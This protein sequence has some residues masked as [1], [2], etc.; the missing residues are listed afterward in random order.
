MFFCKKIL[1]F[2][3]FSLSLPVIT[4]DDKTF[5]RN[6]YNYKI[7]AIA[8][9]CLCSSA[10]FAQEENMDTLFDTGH[11]LAYL[12]AG[13]LISVFAMMF[14]NRLYYY[15]EKKE[16]GELERSFRYQGGNMINITSEEGDVELKL[17]SPNAPGVARYYI[18]EG[19]TASFYLPCYK[20]DVEYT[21]GD[22]WFDD[23][24]GFGEFGETHE[25]E[26]GLR[27]KYS[28]E[29]TWVIFYTMH[30]NPETQSIVRRPVE[31]G[32]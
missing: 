16:T 19:E 28:D 22:I 6:T 26:N 15:R 29:I 30:G 7:L 21:R 11:L 20:Y 23:E 10:S 1:P 18:R 27:F 24:I 32:R 8:L 2:S 3:H 5:M 25:Y 13:L 17:T 31:M 9:F 14:S 12:V 4:T